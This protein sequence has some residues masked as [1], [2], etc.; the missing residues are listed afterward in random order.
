[1]RTKVISEGRSE[2]CRYSTISFVINGKGDFGNGEFWNDE[3]VAVAESLANYI[4]ENTCSPEPIFEGDTVSF[5]YEYKYG[6]MDWKEEVM[7]AY[8]EW[9]R[10]AR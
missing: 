10:T 5:C 3:E 4:S 2:D 8:R 9:K 6:I 7:E 1:M